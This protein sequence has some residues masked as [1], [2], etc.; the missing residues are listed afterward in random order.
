MRLRLHI[1]FALWLLLAGLVPLAIVGGY[2]LVS[3]KETIEHSARQAFAALAQ[4]MANESSRIIYGGI[5]SVSFLAESPLLAADVTDVLQLENE[6][7]KTQSFHPIIKD[8][9]L[10]DANGNI[11]A[12][13]L[14]SFRGDWR[15]TSWYRQAIDGKKVFTG[16]H[17]VLYPFEVVMTTAAPI[18]D[19]VNGEISGV[20]VGQLNMEPLWRI[21]NDV[22]LGG[23]AKSILVDNNGTIVASPE[24]EEILSV[25]DPAI[26][27]LFDS[28]EWG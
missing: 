20:L 3:V 19:P 5:D 26:A 9:T 14:Y 17:A 6:L 11:R 18:V 28:R 4:E 27:G 22:L 23:E 25:V 24:T 8:L 1:K 10:L 12:S 16:V 15:S 7:K 13:A 2:S 21:F